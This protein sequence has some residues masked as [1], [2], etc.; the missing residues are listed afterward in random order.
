[1]RCCDIIKHLES[2]SPLS[3]ACDWDNVGLLAGR[4]DKEVK[5]VYLALDATEEVIRDAILY[6]A[7]ML[8]THHPLIFKA[9]KNIHSEDYIGKRLIALLQHDISYYAMHTNFDVMGMS[10]AAA[11]ELGLKDCKVL[12]ITY[13]DEISKEGEGRYGSLQ[14]IM[15][16]SELA[17]YVK[18]VFQIDSVKVFGNPEMNIEKVAIVPGSGKDYIDLSIQAGVDLLITGDIDHHSGIDANEKG[19]AIMDAGHYG[20]EKLFIPYVQEYFRREL[21]D[22]QVVCAPIQ[23]PFWVV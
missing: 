10:D 12:E 16:L 9:I 20:L 23:N 11:D 4:S 14:R 22:C 17:H 5:T 18:N 3:M 21:S 6:Q 15:A 13:E 7:D 8:I 1:M 2:L 19:L